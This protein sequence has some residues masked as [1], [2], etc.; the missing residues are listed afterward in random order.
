MDMDTVLVTFIERITPKISNIK[1][2]LDSEE[3]K[4][5]MKFCTTL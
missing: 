1:S 3:K 4:F 2:G 5:F